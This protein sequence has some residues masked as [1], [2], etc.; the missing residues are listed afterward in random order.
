MATFALKDRLK[1]AWI[2]FENALATPLM[3]WLQRIF[4]ALLAAFYIAYLLML[5]WKPG[6]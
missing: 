1:R 4:W 2:G 3:D 6:A 5:A